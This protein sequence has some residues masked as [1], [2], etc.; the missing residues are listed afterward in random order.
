MELCVDHSLDE[1]AAAAEQ[2]MTLGSP[3]RQYQ[4][5]AQE[6]SRDNRPYEDFLLSLLEAE[7]AQR[8]ENTRKR[9]ARLD[10]L[11]VDEV[12]FVPFTPE[13]ARLLFQAFSERYLKGSFLITSN[14]GV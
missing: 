1:V 9:L 3:G 2:A 10:L 5:L 11:I 7:V 4:K 8:E 12:G 14:P 6:A 13:G